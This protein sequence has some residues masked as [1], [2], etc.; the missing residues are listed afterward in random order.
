[1]SVVRSSLQ[2]ETERARFLKSVESCSSSQPTSSVSGF[3]SL[4]HVPHYLI[5]PRTLSSSPL[6]P[7]LPLLTLSLT[8]THP[9]TLI[10]IPLPHTPSSSSLSPTLP[11]PH[12]SPPH[13]LFLTPLPSPPHS[14]IL[15]PILSHAAASKIKV[16]VSWRQY[17]FAQGEPKELVWAVSAEYLP[18]QAQGHAHFSC[19]P[20]GL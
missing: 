7:T 20:L 10:L 4:P 2:T 9:H 15:T 1:M 13:S 14:L 18:V 16:G 12:P 6:F 5:L 3:K 11:L 17:S 19:P 8:L